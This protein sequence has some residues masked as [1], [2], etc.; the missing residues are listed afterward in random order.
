[1]HAV[2]LA[3]QASPIVP[4][5]VLIALCHWIG[6]V[7][8]AWC[9][10]Q[11][12][13][14]AEEDFATLPS[15]RSLVTSDREDDPCDR[16][17]VALTALLR[18]ADTCAA[19]YAPAAARDGDGTAERA[20]AACPNRQRRA[21]LAA[22]V[23]AAEQGLLRGMKREALRELAAL[24]ADDGGSGGAEPSGSASG[25][26]ASAAESDEEASGGPGSEEDARTAAG[27]DSVGP[28]AAGLGGAAEE[29][30][31]EITAGQGV[32]RASGQ[33]G[34]GDRGAEA[35]RERAKRQ[36]LCAP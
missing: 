24:H 21:A 18:L 9:R 19:R 36:R 12:L 6:E 15:P 7:A 2:L 10:A 11:T 13:L 1:V 28:A 22:H 35:D 27:P 16:T 4:G 5:D 8:R 33:G 26:E 3:L 23:R 30:G 31:P 25:S 17:A 29:A 14:A 34:G 20:A 32:V